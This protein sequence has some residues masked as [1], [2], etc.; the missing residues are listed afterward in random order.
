MVWEGKDRDRRSSGA[1]GRHDGP[2]LAVWR[3]GRGAPLGRRRG[4]KWICAHRGTASVAGVGGES[5]PGDG[6]L[7][8]E[9]TGDDETDSS[10]LKGRVNVALNVERGDQTL[11]MLSLLVDG[12]VVTSQS[13]GTSAGMTPPEDEAAEQAIH[14]F[15]L[16]LGSHDHDRETGIPTYMNGEHTISAE[17]QIQ[18]EM[19]ADG[20][21][22]HQIVPSNAVAVEFDTTASSRLRLEDSVRVP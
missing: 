10:G 12:A 7:D 5:S 1:A 18:G 14:A 3:G 21:M 2:T 13:F 22:G 16:A 4:R 17:L 20:M 8:G 9:E 6:H 19:G 11:E 15:T